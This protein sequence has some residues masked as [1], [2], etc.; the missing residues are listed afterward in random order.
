MCATGR[1]KTLGNTGSGR[2]RIFLLAALLGLGALVQACTDQKGSKGTTFPTGTTGNA[3][4]SGSIRVQVAINPNTIELG[5]TAGITVLVSNTNGLP[6]EGRLVQLSTSVG[7]LNV[8]DGFTDAAGKFVSALRVTATD[9]ANAAGVTSATVTAFVEGASG[10][11]V[12]NFQGFPV[13]SQITI[14]V[15]PG[16]L[17]CGQSA[18]VTA[19]V[20]G[21]DGSPVSG[22]QVSFFATLGTLSSTGA[23][24]NSSGRA[25]VTFTATPSTIPTCLTGASGSSESVNISAATPGVG[26]AVSVSVTVVRP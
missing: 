15:N 21:I 12:V 26:T 4:T 19:T 11:A 17:Q 22:Q 23:T 13:A 8:V 25:S 16:S 6:L 18:T 1:G 9:L 5:R 24:T 20:T 14:D 2:A 3:E 7:R 10:T